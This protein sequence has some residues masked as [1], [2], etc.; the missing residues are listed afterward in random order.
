MKRLLL[1][2]LSV[3]L[4]VPSA[5]ALAG[6]PEPKDP[7][8]DPPLSL[9][10]IE[11]GMKLKKA[12][13]QWGSHGDC[14]DEQGFEGCTYGKVGRTGN[15]KRGYAE[16]DANRG[17]VFLAVIQAPTKKNGTKARFKGPLMDMISMEGI[18]L[19]SKMEDVK[20]A[21][22]DV[23]KLPGGIGYELKGKGKTAMDFVGYGSKGKRKVTSI[24][25]YKN[26]PE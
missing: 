4:L 16:I 3:A 24:L 23:K 22:P 14:R 12:D 6:M 9:A 8:I 13:K 25:L 10:G 18:G 26:I 11:M 5:S 15:S 2:A 19:G 7:Q 21:Y 20:E 17:K 1:T